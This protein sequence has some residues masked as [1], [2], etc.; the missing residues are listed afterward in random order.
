MTARVVPTA[1][2]STLNARHKLR[3]TAFPFKHL[4]DVVKNLGRI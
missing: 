2:R 1:D 4:I 3:N